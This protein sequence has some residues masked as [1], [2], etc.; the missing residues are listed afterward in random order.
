MADSLKIKRPADPLR[1]NKNQDWE[2]EYW[3]KELNVSRIS[4]LKAITMVGPIVKDIKKYL[5]R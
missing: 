5:N 2:L 1:I 3:S 4:I